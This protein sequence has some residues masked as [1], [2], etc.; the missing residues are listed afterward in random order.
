M[1]NADSAKVVDLAYH[2]VVNDGTRLATTQAVLLNATGSRNTSEWPPYHGS[3]SLRTEP[4]E[5]DFFQRSIAF[6]APAHLAAFS[7][8]H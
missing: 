5:C 1:R 7:N 2:L 8:L 6:I 3:D 4:S